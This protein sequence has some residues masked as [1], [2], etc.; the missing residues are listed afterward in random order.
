MLKSMIRAICFG[1]TLIIKKLCF[2]KREKDKDRQKERE[3]NNRK[4]NLKK[5]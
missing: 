4:L 2:K 1:P 3:E 5:R